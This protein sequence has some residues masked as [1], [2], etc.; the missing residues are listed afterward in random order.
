MLLQRLFVLSVLFAVFGVISACAYHLA[1]PITGEDARLSEP[2]VP[3]GRYCAMD[4]DGA[5]DPDCATLAWREDTGLFEIR[6]SG[7]EPPRQFAL[8]RLGEGMVAAESV[9]VEEIAYPYEVYLFIHT[10]TAFALLPIA[11]DEDAR[12]L[13]GQ[14]SGLVIDPQQD[15]V[16][17]EGGAPEIVRG[18]LGACGRVALARLR[19]EGE[20]PDVAVYAPD[21]LVQASPAQLKS[22]ERLIA[23]AEAL[24]DD[25]PVLTR[26]TLP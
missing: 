13:A 20:V 22:R 19:E 6:D 9:T 26:E 2:P 25:A 14:Y 12:E 10:E 18:F 23:L 1:T 24:A 15:G 5:L 4:E 21:K 17:I 8:V 11:N 16:Y 7:G 3:L